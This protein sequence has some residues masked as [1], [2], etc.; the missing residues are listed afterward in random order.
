[1][2]QWMNQ[3]GIMTTMNPE[4]FVSSVGNHWKTI[5][6]MSIAMN[7]TKNFSRRYDHGN[8]S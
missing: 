3:N 1:M 5:T 7:A 4:G 2:T 8:E 6:G